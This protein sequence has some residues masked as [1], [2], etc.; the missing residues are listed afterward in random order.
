V[1][2]VTGC[3]LASFKDGCRFYLN[4]LSDVLKRDLFL[5]L[6]DLGCLQH[7]VDSCPCQCL[8]LL[9]LCDL[10]TRQIIRSNFARIHDVRRHFEQIAGVFGHF[11]SVEASLVLRKEELHF[12]VTL[13][14]FSFGAV[15]KG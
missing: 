7:H 2:F 10:Q 4:C 5:C 15:G 9:A 11:R 6:E 8:W 14:D 12:V 13:S 3:E 1:F